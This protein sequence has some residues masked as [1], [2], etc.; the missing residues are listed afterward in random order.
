L[1]TTRRQS[2]GFA[3]IVVLW[4]L[5][6]IGFLVA[7]LTGAGRTELLI[8]RNLYANA[9]AEA[10]VEGA[11]AEAL[12]NL[13]DPQ[14]DQ[15]W[16]LDGSVHELR[17]GQSRVVLRLENEA[18][19]INPNFASPALLEGLL[20]VTGSDPET[21]RQLSAGI[22]EWVGAA[23]AGGSPEAVAAEYRVAGLDYRPPRQPIERVDELAL[24]LGMAPQVLA[25]IR[26]HLS[27]YGPGLPDSISADPAVAAALAFVAERPGSFQAKLPTAP[28]AGFVTA[29]ITAT[30]Q[31][32]ENA[33]ATRMAVVRVDPAM[34]RGYVMLARGVSIQ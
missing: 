10:A 29:R 27:V 1:L 8:A 22:A 21:A 4:V 18:A 12:F 9:A 33:E 3:L 15:R 26:P 7:Q 13:S 17:I 24:V 32:A 34:P 23:A 31:G 6:L 28:R 11:I 20:R 30:A 14:P 25:A 5:V 19:R 16:P 2:R